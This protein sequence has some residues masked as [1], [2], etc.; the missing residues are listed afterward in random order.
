MSITRKK[1]NRCNQ[2]KPVAEFRKAPTRF[3]GDGYSNGCK[4]CLLIE[5]RARKAELQESAPDEPEQPIAPEH[6]LAIPYSMPVACAWNGEDFVLTQDNDRAGEQTIYVA[7]HAL[8]RI[9]E[10][11]EGLAHKQQE[12]QLALPGA[13]EA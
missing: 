12:Q 13:A 2:T 7:P 3:G 6:Q 4:A 10:F 1:C 5:S 9:W 11:A 8:R